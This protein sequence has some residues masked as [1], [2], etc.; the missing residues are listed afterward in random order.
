MPF[1][2]G[3]SS[4]PHLF[5]HLLLGADNEIDRLIGTT[6]AR[7]PT[8]QNTPAPARCVGIMSQQHQGT[9]SSSS[10]TRRRSSASLQGRRSSLSYTALFSEGEEGGSSSSSPAASAEDSERAIGELGSVA[11]AAV[12]EQPLSEAEKAQKAK[13][14]E[15][16]R[17]RAKEKFITAKTGVRLRWRDNLGET[18]LN[19]RQSEFEGLFS[20]TYRRILQ[21]RC[22]CVA[23]ATTAA[24][25]LT[26][27]SQS[28]G[29]LCTERVSLRTFVQDG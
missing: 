18:C 1:P 16:Q 3:A 21:R 27:R 6:D 2:L 14:E 13:M 25:S 19:S 15:I 8:T 7:R 5:R 28:H 11:A 17:L 22:H 4:P 24:A 20:H 12:E 10:N 26:K 29:E 9:A 23:A